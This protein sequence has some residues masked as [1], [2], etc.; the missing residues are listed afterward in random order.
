[1]YSDAYPD[2]LRMT[3][4]NLPAALLVL[5]A[6]F[7]V[8]DITGGRGPTLAH[9]NAPVCSLGSMG[10]SWLG[11]CIVGL[12][13]RWGCQSLAR[14]GLRVQHRAAQHGTSLCCSR[15]QLRLLPVPCCRC[16]C[17]SR[18]NHHPAQALR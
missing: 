15:N 7:S 11:W 17:H 5:G 8:D 10:L 18:D 3:A 2:Y 6:L 14:R 1:M 16:C 13:H 12:V 9:Q 4:L